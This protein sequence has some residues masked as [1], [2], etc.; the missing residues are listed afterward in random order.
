MPAGKGFSRVAVADV[1]QRSFRVRAKTFVLATGATEN[2][3]LL[4]ASNDRRPRGL[5]NQHDLVGRF[6][7]EHPH[8][9]SGH[10]VASNASFAAP[11]SRYR[12]Q[13]VNGVP[14]MAKWTIAEDVRRREQLLGY[15]VSIHEVDAPEISDGT[16]SAVRLLRGVREHRPPPRTG[17][18]LGR[19]IAGLPGIAADLADRRRR[20]HEGRRATGRGR[21]YRMDH[22][23]EQLPDRES[24]VTLSDQRDALGVPRVRLDWRLS[25]TDLRSM[26]RSQEILDEELRRAGIGRL[27]IA[28][29]DATPPPGL[30][31]GWHHMGTTR[32]DDHPKRGV[33]DRNGAVHG[34]ANLYVTGSSVFPTVGY[35]NPLLTVGALAIRLADHLRAVH[36]A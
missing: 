36:D 33:V 2:A 8:V 6:F 7:M 22:M 25:P 26:A 10:F 30:K 23:G 13:R 11:T 3:R 1:P 14:V 34:I 28:M 31:G 15:C 17:R 29:D 27:Q 9:W 21:V 12:I 24:R 19:A 32:M 20:K 4:L 18:H 35:A 16:Y 5:G